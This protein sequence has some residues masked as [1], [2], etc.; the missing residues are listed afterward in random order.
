MTVPGLPDDRHRADHV[1]LVADLS[2]VR[3]EVQTRDHGRGLR[4][5]HDQDAVP[6]DGIDERHVAVEQPAQSPARARR[7]LLRSVGELSGKDTAVI[8]VR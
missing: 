2:Q 5:S 6:R 1:A 7:S 3:L 8:A 4:G